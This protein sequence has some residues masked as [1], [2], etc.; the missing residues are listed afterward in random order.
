MEILRLREYARR[1]A[2]DQARFRIQAELARPRE[3]ALSHLTV[4]TVAAGVFGSIAL[5]FVLMG[6]GW[7]VLAPVGLVL[8]ALFTGVYFGLEARR[9]PR[10][11]IVTPP[12]PP[13]N[14]PPD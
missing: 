12:R 5:A 7:W 11:G 1:R 13:G 4:S 6:F 2:L 10:E 14:L 8:P 9:A 3:R